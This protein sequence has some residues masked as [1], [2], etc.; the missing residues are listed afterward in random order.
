MFDCVAGQSFYLPPI[1]NVNGIRNDIAILTP[2][3]V[4][5]DIKRSFINIG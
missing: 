2:Q 3:G 4:G 5:Y 1:R